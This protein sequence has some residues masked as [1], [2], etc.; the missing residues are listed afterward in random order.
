MP[1]EAVPA[2]VQDKVAAD[3]MAAFERALGVAPG[4]LP[5]PL[6]YRWVDAAR[7]SVLVEWQG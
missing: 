7:A 2:A 4:S 5:D 3:M 6:F 1:Q